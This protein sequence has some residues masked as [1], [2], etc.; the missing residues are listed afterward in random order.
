M[1]DL[2][3]LF[4]YHTFFLNDREHVFNRNLSNR[5]LQGEWCHNAEIDHFIE[6]MKE[7]GSGT[8]LDI[9]TTD[10]YF[11]LL[12]DKLGARSFTTDACDRTTRRAIQ[13]FLGK[14]DRFIHTNLYQLDKLG[15]V[16]DYIWCQ[17]VICH[18]EHPLLAFRT[19]RKI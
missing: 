1:I 6:H 17:D 4:W 19:F 15:G 14:E 16:Y 13:E 18:L 10:G 5:V 8:L 11:S 2:D 9:G 7:V 12:F 3:A